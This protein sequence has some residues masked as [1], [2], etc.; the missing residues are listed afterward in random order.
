MQCQGLWA[1]NKHSCRQRNLQRPLHD[2]VK[3]IQ[4]QNYNSLLQ[5]REYKHTRE[6]TLP[7]T[8]ALQSRSEQKRPLTTHNVDPKLMRPDYVDKNEC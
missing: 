5:E 6:R 3:D 1:P 4:Q 7:N 8:G 2:E